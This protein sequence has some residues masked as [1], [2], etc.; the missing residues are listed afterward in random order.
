M[1]SDA[2]AILNEGGFG[3]SQ[4][5]KCATIYPADDQQF[6][7]LVEA[8]S[9][10]EDVPGPKVPDDVWLGGFVFARYG[11]FNPII[12]RDALGQIGRYITGRDGS[13][14]A[15][16]YDS[17]LA[18]SRFLHDFDGAPIARLRRQHARLPAGIL[19][20]R[21]LII[22]VLRDSGKGALLQ[23]LDVQAKGKVRPMLIKQGRAHTLSDLHGY[24]IRDR[25][26]HQKAMHGIAA[27]AGISPHC[28]PY[29][30][31]DGDG[32]LPIEFQKNDNFELRVQSILQGATIDEVGIAGRTNIKEILV[33]VGEQLMRLHSLGIV[34]RDLSPSNVLL[35]EN[36]VATLSDLE[37]AWRPGAPVFG[38]GTPGFMAPEQASDATPDPSADSYAYAAM[39][40]YAIAG[41]DPRRLPVPACSDDWH[42][43]RAVGRSLSPVLWHA[44]HDGLAENPRARPSVAEL[45]RAVQRL[46]TSPIHRPKASEAPL[47]NDL[48]VAGT[49]TLAAPALLEPNL[50]L[51]LS[52]P[53]SGNGGP[54]IRRSLNRGVAGVLYYCALYERYRP[55]DPTLR[56]VCRTNAKWLIADRAAVDYG[57]PGL[58]F[59][60]AGVLL[61]L[62][63][64]RAARLVEFEEADVAHL[65]DVVVGAPLNWLDVTHG[66]AGQI[67]AI[68]QLRA[69]GGGSNYDLDAEISRRLYTLKEA[70][71]P[72]GF[73]IVPEG[74]DGIS[75]EV[76][77]GFA[78]GVSGIAHVLATHGPKYGDR[79]CL[80]AAIRAAE[81][82]TS[83]SI[84][85][86][87]G[88]LTWSYSDKK[89]E[90]WTWW[91]HGGPGIASL[92][93]ALYEIT[94]NTAFASLADRCFT[95][96]APRLNPANLSLCH[97]AAGLGELLL[98]ASEVLGRSD[99]RERADA[100]AAMV[101][102]RHARGRQDVYWV[103]ED[104]NFVGADLMVGMSGVLHFLLRL[105][106]QDP[107]LGFFL[108]RRP[109]VMG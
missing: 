52:A 41:T 89:T 20:G 99:L 96:L 102:A 98:D 5:G 35:T 91:C 24:D 16:T 19:A 60:E 55:L 46:E 68:D 77:T 65:W 74:V 85:T 45:C 109:T 50:G 75:G 61:S 21:Y 2:A 27:A 26:R 80:A 37:I 10:I 25:L 69:F 57:M 30:E 95:A 87:N 36:D 73:W 13:L 22:D 43:I 12:Q 71:S 88:S 66:A 108:A 67:V 92:F 9:R 53:I 39:I 32:Y 6:S 105:S 1:S 106:E 17:S 11:G 107:A 93:I 15:D 90:R 100:L 103:V 58:H 28:D 81:W 7:I 42:S 8:L 48:L 70:Q 44:V 31:V 33:T 47:L 38:K 101:C 18:A 104:T 59:G 83:V 23:A 4:I 86:D 49:T 82:L 94:G 40:L 14:V 76:L 78:H 34:H 79:A 63:A 29:F 51:W 64:A 54:E 72:A 84:P 3:E 62:Y 97:G 56:G